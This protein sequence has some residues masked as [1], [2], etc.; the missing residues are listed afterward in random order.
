VPFQLILADPTLQHLSF[1]PGKMSQAVIDDLQNLAVLELPPDKFPD[2]ERTRI[3][4]ALLS[5]CHVTEMDLSYVV[6]ANLLRLRLGQKYDINPFA[7]LAKPIGKKTGLLQKMKPPSPGQKIKRINE[8]A[9]KA[10]M[11]RIGEALAEI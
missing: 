10:G 2:A 4:L 8:L 1:G 3:R 9:E 7:D 6:L 11:P 5:C